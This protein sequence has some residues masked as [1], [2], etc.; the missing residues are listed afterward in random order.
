MKPYQ[1][2]IDTN[3]V[4]SALLSRSGASFRL[5]NLLGSDLLQA[6]VSVP[7]VLEYEDAASR[8]VSPG[9]LTQQ[10]IGDVLDYLCR[11]ANHRRVHFLWRPSL[12]DPKDDHVL[13]L[14]VE[15]GC[16]YIVTYNT[17]DFSGIEQFG[18]RAITPKEFL[19]LLGDIP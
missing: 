17:Q 1:V 8:L 2:V 5:L 4:V 14:A 13:E 3:V 18:V 7:L 11:V 6:N 12:K 19:Q 10:D 15:A 16:R 9:G